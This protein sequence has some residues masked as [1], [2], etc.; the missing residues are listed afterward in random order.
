MTSAEY[1][2]IPNLPH[3]PGRS[4]YQINGLQFQ[5]IA[6]TDPAVTTLSIR[7]FYDERLL[8]ARVVTPRERNSRALIDIFRGTYIRAFPRLLPNTLGSLW[9]GIKVAI[10]FS[11]ESWDVN[12]KESLLVSTFKNQDTVTVVAVDALTQPQSP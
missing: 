10:G 2:R 11:F 6:R 3:I 8:F 9:I 4:F 1:D 12:P 7:F 5:K